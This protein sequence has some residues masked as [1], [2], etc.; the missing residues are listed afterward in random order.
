[1][2][3]RGI[4]NIIMENNT[5]KK[6][7]YRT[8]LLLSVVATLVF[9]ACSQKL[10]ELIPVNKE[11]GDDLVTEVL[12]LQHE[13]QTKATLGN[14]NSNPTKAWENTDYIGVWT[15][16]SPSSG[17]LQCCSV[18][19][20]T[21][22]V[23]LYGGNLQRYNYA[24]YPYKYSLSGSVIPTF[25]VGEGTLSVDLPNTY[26]YAELGGIK[27]TVPMVAKNLSTDGSTLTFYSV[28]AL[29]RIFVSAIP[30]RAD[31]LVVSFDKTV[32]GSFTVQNL[33]SF[34][35]VTPAPYIAI[36]SESSA[37]TVTV[38]LIPGADYAGAVINIPIPQGTVNVISV[39]AYDGEEL[40]MIEGSNKSKLIA[41]WSAARAHGKKATV[42]Y[43]PSIGSLYI[44]PGKLYT[45]NTGTLLM[46]DHWYEHM[47]VLSGAENNG[48]GRAVDVT[49][50]SFGWD[51]SES[52][53]LKNRTHFN[54]NEM[55]HLFHGTTPTWAQASDNTS[56]GTEDSAT[57]YPMSKVFSGT[58]W[59]VPFEDDFLSML[60]DV[61]HPR[62]G[63]ALNGIHGVKTLRILVTGMNTNEGTTVYS[64]SEGVES[65]NPQDGDYIG[66]STTYQAGVLFLP[67]NV[68]LSGT[69]I[70]IDYEK[71]SPVYVGTGNYFD[72]KITKDNLE[73]LISNG[74]A[75]FPALGHWLK[76]NDLRFT[77]I[78]MFGC[79]WSN[80]QEKGSLSVEHY[81]D[82]AYYLGMN[83]SSV[84]ADGP[85]YKFD[86]QSIRLVRSVN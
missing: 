65:T 70:S 14:E 5:M 31:K 55:Y 83:K 15:G 67:D 56:T 45:D 47:L 8:S 4:N 13:S 39:A 64:I 35:D 77:N 9:S 60:G 58:T 28:G 82:G 24:V 26:D 3:G 23:N 22:S 75:F 2:I 30:S 38:N 18:S 6:N 81:Y 79:Y 84:N 72:T 32:T 62:S 86:Y 61:S 41:N 85:H 51:N 78:G 76:T 1:M 73:T 29:A 25:T 42:A 27:N 50:N 37:S 36:D 19:E 74:C 48:E 43:T 80:T 44:S 69:F 52:Y 11:N 59:R 7:L 63:A 16:T 53:S 12:T 57:S 10:E 66:P 21:I 46:A 49:V 68:E 71:S 33:S 20:N 40:L 54:W 17:S 34:S